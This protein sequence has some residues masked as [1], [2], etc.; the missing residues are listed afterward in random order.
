MNKRFAARLGASRGEDREEMCSEACSLARRGEV[1]SK[2]IL[3]Y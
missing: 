1:F 2:K 3:Y